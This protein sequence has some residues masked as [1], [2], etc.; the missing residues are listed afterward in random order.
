[1][2]LLFWDSFDHYATAHELYKWT[3][4]FVDG[5]ST[6]TIGAYG[7]NSTNGLRL[8]H[9]A[10]QQARIRRAL[11][12]TPDTI[13]MGVATTISAMP[14]TTAGLLQLLDGATVQI[15]LR[16]GNDGTLSVYRGALGV[17]LG[18]SAPG[19]IDPAVYHYIEIKAVIDNAAGSVEVHIDEVQVIDVS[20]V[21]TQL[22]GTPQVT[23]IQLGGGIDGGGNY[24]H[25]DLYVCDDSGSNCND[26]LGDSRLCFLPPTAD[27]V[28]ADWTPSAGVDHYAMVDEVDPDDD[29][30]TNDSATPTDR[31]S[32]DMDN[33]PIGVVGAVHAVCAVICSRKDDAGVRTLQPSVRVGGTDYDGASVNIPSSYS[34]HTLYAWEVNP[35]TAAPWLVA[36]VNAPLESG[37]E[38][39]A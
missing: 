37:Y 32:F 35:D 15:D 17:L 6:V 29:A 22:S 3:S 4:A 30:T 1:M 33:L 25:D 23:Q 13:I 36:E 12:S 11:S 28:H 26:F 39:V 27:G 5:A 20:G 21:D 2:A 16:V 9:Q 10:N 18:S 7:R 24:D 14:A 19:I 38:L 34:Y 8:F 31:D